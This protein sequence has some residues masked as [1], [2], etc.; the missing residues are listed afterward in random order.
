MID[1][2]LK[3]KIKSVLGSHYAKP[4]IE[5]LNS[6][7]VYAENGKPYQTTSIRGI[8]NAV[9]NRENLVIEAH[10]VELLNNKQLERKKQREKWEKVVVPE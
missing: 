5:Y 1:Q 8:V 7:G 3:A 4:I 10:I 6:K 2:E 9:H